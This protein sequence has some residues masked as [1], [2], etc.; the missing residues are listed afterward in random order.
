[1]KAI[2]DS[3]ALFWYL[4]GDR[5]L[6]NRAKATIESYET[7]IIPTI[8]LLE[9]FEVCSAKNKVELFSKL[10]DSLPTDTLMVYPLDLSLVRSYTQAPRGKI[11]IHDRV[12]LATAQI[13]NLPIITKDRELSKIYPKT[14][15]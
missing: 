13:L 12:I 3:H 10:L 7:I 8:V 1:M 11:D 9:A 2:L 5:K 6:S 15:W 14:I 4:T